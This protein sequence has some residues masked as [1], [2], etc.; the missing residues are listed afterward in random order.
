MVFSSFGAVLAHQEDWFENV[1]EHKVF[2]ATDSTN[3]IHLVWES[4]PE[5][6][7]EVSYSNDNPNGGLDFELESLVIELNSHL[8]YFE[9]QGYLTMVDLAIDRIQRARDYLNSGDV[10]KALD[11]F[12]K[13]ENRL[14]SAIHLNPD[15]DLLED[16]KWL[17]GIT[18]RVVEPHLAHMEIQNGI[19][20]SIVQEAWHWYNQGVAEISEEKFI[21][22]IRSYE[23]AY[24]VYQKNSKPNLMQFKSALRL[25]EPLADSRGPELLIQEPWEN[26]E[27]INAAWV[28]I[29]E[30]DQYAVRYARSLDNTIGEKWIG[31][32]T[33]AL[34]DADTGYGV[35]LD[36]ILD[37][38]SYYSFEFLDGKCLALDD[39]NGLPYIQNKNPGGIY[40]YPC[41]YLDMPDFNIKPVSIDFFRS[42]ISVPFDAGLDSWGMSI[43]V[44]V[45]NEGIGTVTGV[46]MKVFVDDVYQ[47]TVTIPYIPENGE[48][49]TTAIQLPSLALGQ[50]AVKV[51]VDPNND[52]LEFNEMDNIRIR[53]LRKL[54]PWDDEDDDGI[55]NGEEA[56]SGNDGYV[57]NPLS[58]DT[59]NDELSDPD[60]INSY[61]TNPTKLDT[62]GDEL[63]DG[64]EVLTGWAITVNGVTS[65]V[66]SDPL[67]I[68]ADGDTLTD[69]YEMFRGTSPNLVDTDG[70]TRNDDR[71]IKGWSITVNGRTRFVSSLPTNTNS[72]TDSLNDLQE[73]TSHTDPMDKDTDGDFLNDDNEIN[74]H[75]TNPNEKDTDGDQLNDNNELIEGTFPTLSNFDDDGDGVSDEDP[76]NG[77]DDDGD[78][79]IDE[80]ADGRD[81]DG[82][83]LLDGVELNVLGTWDKYTFEFHDF[84]DEGQLRGFEDLIPNTRLGGEKTSYIRIPT[85]TF[86]GEIYGIPYVT[87]ATF[88]DVL[89]ADSTF[90]PIYF[91][92]DQV[93]LYG[94]EYTNTADFDI[95]SDN[96]LGFH[97]VNPVFKW[98]SGEKDMSLLYSYYWDEDYYWDG[99]DGRNFDENDIIYSA[100]SGKMIE[101][102]S[103]TQTPEGNL[104]VVWSENTMN[105][106]STPYKVVSSILKYSTRIGNTWSTP[107]NIYDGGSI[108]NPSIAIQGDGTITICWEEQFGSV[109]EDGEYDYYVLTKRKEEGSVWSTNEF[110]TPNPSRHSAII[111]TDDETYIVWEDEN[112]TNGNIVLKYSWYSA[113]SQAISITIST[114]N[115]DASLSPDS[116]DVDSS[117][118]V[119]LV[120]FQAEPLSIDLYKYILD[121][122]S[123][124]AKL[125]WTGSIDEQTPPEIEIDSNDDISIC[126]NSGYIGPYSWIGE[127]VHVGRC[128]SNGILEVDPV[129]NI[130]S[131]SAGTGKDLSRPK[132]PTIDVGDDGVYEFEFQNGFLDDDIIGFW[133]FEAA[134][135]K[136]IITNGIPLD[137]S[138]ID[139]PIVY[140]AETGGAGI[141]LYRPVIIT[142]T[143]VLDPR[144]PDTDGDGYNDGDELATHYL[145]PELSDTDGDGIDDDAEGG[146]STNP[147]F[148]DTDRDFFPDGSERDYWDAEGIGW[149]SGGVNKLLDPDY[150]GDWLPDGFEYYGWETYINRVLTTVTSDPKIDNSDSDSLLDYDEYLHGTNPENQDTDGDSMGNTNPYEPNLMDD[151]ELS[152]FGTNP[153]DSDSDYDTIND[154][155]E[156]FVYFTLPTSDDTD[157]DSLTDD[158]ELFIGKE[159]EINGISTRVYSDPNSDDGDGDE[160]KDMEEYYIYNT[161][162]SDADTDGDYLSD[163][164]ELR[165]GWIVRLN[166]DTETDYRVYSSP[167]KDDTE[168]DNLNDW[169]EHY[170]ASD[171]NCTDTDKDWL[172]DYDEIYGWAPIY[173]DGVL[174]SLIS[175]PTR[176]HS[177]GD[178]LTDNYEW[179]Y[180]TNP[181]CFDTDKDGLDDS[182]E[183]TT[184]T[185]ATVSDTDGDGLKDGEEVNTYFTR[186][187]NPDTDYDTL[188]DWDEINIY[189]T[190]PL[191]DDTD[192]DTLSDDYELFL[193]TN[194]K[195][196]DSDSDGLA[197]GDEINIYGTD[198]TKS[199]TDGDGVMD[200]MDPDPLLDDVAPVP[201][202]ISSSDFRYSFNIVIADLSSIS[203]IPIQAGI[204]NQLIIGPSEF[205]LTSTY[206]GGN[207]YHIALVFS[208]DYY[209]LYVTR[210]LI[211]V[212]DS[213]GNKV[214][215]DIM[216]EKENPN[217]DNSLSKPTAGNIDF[218]F[219]IIG[220]YGYQ[221]ATTLTILLPTAAIATVAIF[222]ILVFLWIGTAEV[223]PPPESTEE[224]QTID[225]VGGAESA[226]AVFNGVSGNIYLLEGYHLDGRGHGWEHIIAIYNWVTIDFLKTI[227]ETGTPVT[228]G[229]YINYEL[230]LIEDGYEVV[231]RVITSN[232]QVIT[233]QRIFIIEDL[234]GIELELPE[235][236]RTHLRIDHPDDFG[237]MTDA[238]I[239]DLI[240][241]MVNDPDYKWKQGDKITYV[242]IDED[243]NWWIVIE[244]Y[245]I[246]VT[247]Y[248]IDNVKHPED[249]DKEDYLDV[250]NGRK[251][252]EK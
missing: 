60:E 23:E 237:G 35:N 3:N 194:P 149:N 203:F 169:D 116:L 229:D 156:I 233:M 250:Y 73:Y 68:D 6:V 162:P 152:I 11:Y 118:S 178:G 176:I 242:W 248:M 87:S 20:S 216:L 195:E 141:G 154:W 181:K 218:V 121:G 147:L 97:L 236:T 246:I 5:G 30:N 136:Y 119:H 123:Y 144:N 16:M 190:D 164:F 39:D 183:R 59:D 146:Y 96:T 122:M 34:T 211:E 172:D 49:T 21:D 245:G 41:R 207:E 74:T 209:H 56:V 2:S 95:I 67:A 197:D 69:S 58:S 115:K 92:T 29:F 224:A 48:Y 153:S 43:K 232:D 204:Y 127:S 18:A 84:E 196:I 36:S 174:T 137:Q 104:H 1:V 170:W 31:I 64:F 225:F 42:G 111:A 215:I 88:S 239:R 200:Y 220:A 208:N 109:G 151:V 184:S 108:R 81:S 150:D 188:N 148:K 61:S 38:L 221:S 17:A 62:D 14:E 102:P 117:G 165:V 128:G 217:D 240:D 79:L 54:I 206:L 75:R 70:D 120:S 231:Y 82:D 22:A 114:Q 214:E 125:E 19:S 135:N 129:G 244:R 140:T 55:H 199:D 226:L 28:E 247:S 113:N 33:T 27:P 160:L 131:F 52:F 163:Y 138:Y 53:P 180:G 192:L 235:K 213:Y 198:P 179:Q 63:S 161:N 241:E 159:I 24:K 202:K 157:G 142:S 134:L 167:I 57:T 71:E 94:I 212:K 65:T 50:H 105:Y 86:N 110:H 66:Y 228:E 47:T 76:I 32:D 10:D 44:T 107:I 243:G 15:C 93:D 83:G 132:N 223:T 112:P 91:Y 40:Y 77:L 101:K 51:Q 8:R 12:E 251:V 175:N 106:H 201:E 230:T 46:P 210:Y 45:R 126:W 78:G 171:P 124:T 238:E 7:Y 80:D 37:F 186:P 191:W 219:V 130:I 72:D 89:G 26:W 252:W 98:Q 9:P 249:W 85:S 182:E 205:T 189:G 173:I 4:D 193:G 143:L 166:L 187:N 100:P 222:A 13:A 227:V 177:D 25:S 185:I 103:I 145:N 155:D 139:V 234:W 133:D 99:H 90:D 158:F 168:G